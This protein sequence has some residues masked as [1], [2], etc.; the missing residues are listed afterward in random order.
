MLALAIAI[1]VLVG[2]LVLFRL[3]M[4]ARSGGKRWFI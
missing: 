1:A 2:S 3:A 4:P